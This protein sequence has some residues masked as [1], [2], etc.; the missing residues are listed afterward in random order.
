MTTQELRAHLVISGRVQGV[1]Y[2]ASAEDEAQRLGLKGLVRNL[3]GGEVEAVVE[4]EV[5]AVEAFIAW[6][7]QG[8]PLSRVDRVDVS[9]QAPRGEFKDFRVS[10]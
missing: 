4:G 6:C 1:G 7:R 8:P 5:A 2:R 3:W 10:S 9:R